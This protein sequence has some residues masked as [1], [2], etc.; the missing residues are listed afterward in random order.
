MTSIEQEIYEEDYEKDCPIQVKQDEENTNILIKEVIEELKLS[1]KS[2]LED[3]K[4]IDKIVLTHNM[5]DEF[6][7]HLE[8][9]CQKKDEIETILEYAEKANENHPDLVIRSRPNISRLD[10]VAILTDKAMINAYYPE[11]S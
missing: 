4:E 9:L 3:K 5:V 1:Y 2:Y 6:E 10:Y 7:K 8:L 11:I